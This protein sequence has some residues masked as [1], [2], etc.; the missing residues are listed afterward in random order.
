MNS[1]RKD[2]AKK[3][4]EHGQA[5]AKAW[6]EFYDSEMQTLADRANATLEAESIIRDAKIME[7]SRAI[8][9]LKEHVKTMP[10]VQHVTGNE[11]LK[12]DVT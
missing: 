6:Q 10:V 11:N 7:P 1:D 9:T 4:E 2:A 5:V 3:A 8:E 12:A